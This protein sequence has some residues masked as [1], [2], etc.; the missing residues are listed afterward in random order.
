MN[1]P[2]CGVIHGTEGCSIFGMHDMKQQPYTPSRRDYFALE[3]MKIMVEKGLVK[4]DEIALGARC[5]AEA[6]IAELDN[7][8]KS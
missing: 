6:M 3:A 5:L 7:G 1:C 2:K 8:D 4:Y